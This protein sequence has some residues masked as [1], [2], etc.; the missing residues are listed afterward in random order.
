MNSHN[1]KQAKQWM[2]VERI[3][4]VA[5]LTLLNRVQVYR[6]NK[7]QE[8]QCYQDYLQNMVAKI[9]DDTKTIALLS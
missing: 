9:R 7:L 3:S 2:Y 1:P 8:S 5:V 4:L 6:Q